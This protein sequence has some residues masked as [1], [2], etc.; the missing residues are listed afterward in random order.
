MF[1]LN[2][3][4]E[5]GPIYTCAG[6][7]ACIISSFLGLKF[8]DGTIQTT[9]ATG[10]GG[11]GSVTSVGLSLP[12]SVFTLSGTPVTTI[13]TLTGTFASQ[14]VNTVFAGPTSGSGTPTFRMLAASDIPSGGN[15]TDTGTDGI[16]IGNGSG[17]VIGSGT[18]IAQHVADT[19]HNGYLASTDWNTFAASISSLTGDVTATGPGAA[20][21]TLATVN[22][23]T[24]SFGSSTSIPNF[25]VNGKGLITAAGGNAVVAPAGTLTGS[26]LASNVLTSS[27]TTVGTIGTGVWNGTTIALANGGTGQTSATAAF[28]ALNPMTTTGD[29]I[30]ESGT[31]NASRL[32]IGTT[33]AI[34]QVVSGIPA[35]TAPGTNKEVLFNSSGV[36]TGQT[37]FEFAPSPSNILTVPNITASGTISA[38]TLHI[39]NI[40]NQVPN[41]AIDLLHSILQYENGM[42]TVDWTNGLLGFGYYP[43]LNPSLNWMSDLLIDQ[44]SGYNS[45][46]WCECK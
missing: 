18:T 30:Y 26:T 41:P 9:A 5:Y 16:V 36:I 20:G 1:S 45:L 7:Y 21:A 22:T 23:N 37:N 11:G 40:D 4:A 6:P 38:G 32:A 28:N 27:L 25:T 24:G 19:S 33:G 3:M 15:L 46:D 29:I 17:A 2:A 43:D 34:L 35:W 14:S 12:S 31:G 10:G 13:G 42:G 44:N 39:N 8:P